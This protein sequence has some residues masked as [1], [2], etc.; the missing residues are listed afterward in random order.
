MSFLECRF[1]VASRDE[2]GILYVFKTT[3]V[4]AYADYVV[5]MCRSENAPSQ[6]VQ[7][8]IVKSR[9]FN[10][11]K[12]GHI[13]KQSSCSSGP[14]IQAGV[15]AEKFPQLDHSTAATSRDTTAMDLCA[16]PAHSRLAHAITFCQHDATPH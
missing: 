10:H 12:C 1:G 6:S 14:P 4:L 2:C 5:V 15:S 9:L 11:Q 3:E 16:A 8:D 13:Y 7:R